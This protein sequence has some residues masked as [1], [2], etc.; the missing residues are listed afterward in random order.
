M[1]PL[2]STHS[3]YT[4]NEESSNEHSICA[5]DEVKGIYEIQRK[6]FIINDIFEEKI[7]TKPIREK[8]EAVKERIQERSENTSRNEEPKLDVQPLNL[9]SLLNKIQL[10]KPVKTIDSILQ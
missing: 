3:L 10:N 2:S 8:I 9:N 6:K 7:E 5:D 4:L 1:K